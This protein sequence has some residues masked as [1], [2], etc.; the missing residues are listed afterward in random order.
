MTVE[1][2]KNSKQDD[3]QGEGET[4]MSR[5]WPGPCASVGDLWGL[6]SIGVNKQD[7]RDGI[8]AYKIA[9]HTS[10]PPNGVSSSTSLNPNGFWSRSDLAKGFPGAQVRDNALSKA[11]FE[12]RWEDQ[13]NLSLDPGRA[14]EF[15]DETMPKEAYLFAHAVKHMEVRMT[16]ECSEPKTYAISLLNWVLANRK[17]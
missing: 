4:G 16:R 7:M 10:E 15:H 1:S 8:I 6:D 17:P 12:F 9:A 13:F 11:R 5:S 2:I 3:V 14:R